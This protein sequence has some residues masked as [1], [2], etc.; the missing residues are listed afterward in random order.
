[1]RCSLGISNFL[2]E[3]S[4]LS[5]PIVFLY[6]L[7][8]ITEKGFPISPRY[9]L[10]LCIQMGTSFLFS[11]LKT[12]VLNLVYRP[13]LSLWTQTCLSA[14]LRCRWP[15][16]SPLVPKMCRAPTPL[17][18][19]PQGGP[20][21]PDLVRSVTQSRPL[22]FSFTSHATVVIAQFVVF[23]VDCQLPTRMSVQKTMST[24]IVS[25]RSRRPQG[26]GVLA[27][28]EPPSMLECIHTHDLNLGCVCVLRRVPLLVTPWTVCSLPGSS[29]HGIFQARI[30]ERVVTSRGSSWPKDRTCIS[31]ALWFGKGIL[32]HC[33]T[34]ETPVW[35]TFP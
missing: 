6:F 14:L 34:W 35:V 12:P 20:L 17:E 27:Y 5:H 8:L 4:S 2:E 30:L 22:C 10:E 16:G 25:L 19:P 28:N 7:A 18:P 15:F 9:S 13:L 26:P 1:M 32:Q 23:L 11:L 24:C 21:P 29:V 33:V 31:Y 3:I